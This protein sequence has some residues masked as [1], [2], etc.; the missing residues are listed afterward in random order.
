M[1]RLAGRTAASMPPRESVAAFAAHGRDH[2]RVPLR[3]PPAPAPGGAARARQWLRRR[4]ARGDRGAGQLARRAGRA[5][6]GRPPGRGPGGNRGPDHGSRA[7]RDRPWPRAEAA[8]AATSTPRASPTSSGA[9]PDGDDSGRR[10][11]RQ[12]G[13]VSVRASQSSVSPRRGRGLRTGWTTGTCASAAAKA[14]ALGLVT[15]TVPTWSRWPCP[16]AGGSSSPVGAGRYGDPCRRREGRR[17]RPRLHRRGPR[18]GRGGSGPGRRQR[19]PSSGPAPVW[20]RS[21][22]PGW[23][24]LS[25]APPST[26]CPAG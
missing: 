24:W 26:R 1:T 13:A 18:H 6:D 2:G 15:G 12:R 11:A 22:S 5:D 20:A 16:T 23:A 10:A 14:A 7:G 21:P 4:H 8:P 9:G 3:R 17:R 19:D 25:A